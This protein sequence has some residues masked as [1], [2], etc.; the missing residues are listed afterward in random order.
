MLQGNAGTCFLLGQDTFKRLIETRDYLSR[1]LFERHLS[2]FLESLQ[3][4]N[5]IQSG[6]HQKKNKK[7]HV[8]YQRP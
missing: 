8:G 2:G 4:T 5:V 1:H 7:N 3:T 6:S